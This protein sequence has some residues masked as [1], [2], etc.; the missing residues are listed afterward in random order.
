[1]LGLGRRASSRSCS[2]AFL[3]MFVQAVSWVSAARAFALPSPLTIAAPTGDI[4]PVHDPSGIVLSEGY[5]FYF[6]TSYGSEGGVQVRRTTASASLANISSATWASH[7]VV[8]PPAQMPGWLDKRVP[9]PP[10]KPGHPPH[11][12]SRTLWAPDISY[13]A[14]SGEVRG[15]QR[16]MNIVATFV[17]LF[18]EQY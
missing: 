7:S 9:L 15:R 12:G 18:V 1:M 2:L 4:T 5:G 6:S 11:L 17:L 8:F 16:S 13:H 10:P 3:A 14:P